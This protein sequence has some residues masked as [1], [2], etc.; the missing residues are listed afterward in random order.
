M[1]LSLMERDRMAVMRQVSEGVPTPTAGAAQL[2][3]DAPSHEGTPERGGSRARATVRP[4]TG[5]GLLA[6]W[7]AER[8]HRRP[9][10]RQSSRPFNPT[11]TNRRQRRDFIHGL[12]GPGTS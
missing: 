1:E 12:Q 5:C 8:T 7:S 4:F 3:G 2:G 6:T 9:P 10:S 11:P